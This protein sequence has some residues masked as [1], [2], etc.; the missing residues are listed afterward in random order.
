LLTVI[1]TDLCQELGEVINALLLLGLH[2]DADLGKL[3]IVIRLVVA[4]RDLSELGLLLLDSGVDLGEGIV[5]IER[6][7]SADLS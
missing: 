6:L 5:L 7:V 4:G 3:G 1:N 2:L